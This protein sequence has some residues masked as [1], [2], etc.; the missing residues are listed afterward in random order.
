VRHASD[1]FAAGVEA[2][3]RA[4]APLQPQR[5]AMTILGAHGRGGRTVWSGGLVEALLEFGFSP[6]AGRVAL[7][8]L[9]RRGLLERSREGRLIHYRLTEAGERLMREGD[10]RIFSFGRV[11]GGDDVWTVVWHT[12]P[13]E[14]GLARSWL[15]RRLRFLGFGSLQDGTWVAPHDMA[16]ALGALLDDTGLAEHSIVLVGRPAKPPDLEALVRRAWNL[17]DVARRYQAFAAAAS[18][19]SGPPASDLQAFMGRTLVTH[20]F[21]QFPSD[22][23]EL[24]DDPLGLHPLRERALGLFDELFARLEAPAQRHFDSV[25]RSPS[26][27]AAA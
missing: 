8:R 25:T 7:G 20:L 22:D 10:R 21:R 4:A 13:E 17:E 14:Q 24:P 11:S 6:G 26:A 9:V 12:I 1:R 18:S 16:E 23:P 15:A 27:R 2:L 5:L 19:L 3:A